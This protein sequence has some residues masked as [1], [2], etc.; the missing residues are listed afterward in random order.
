MS[1]P[2]RFRQLHDHARAE[3]VVSWELRRD[4]LQR[5]RHL[6]I[7]H[8]HDIATAISH[9]FGNRSQH[10]TQFLEVFTSLQ[11]VDHALAHG[12]I[13]MQPQSRR[14][15]I[16]YKPA[17]NTLLP[18]PLGVVG[19]ITPWNYP[20][21]L[22]IGPLSGALA[23]GNLTMI[24]LSEH[25]P[26]FG[27]LFDQLIRQ[28]FSE[29]EITV[30]NG[31]IALAREFCALPFDHLVF[32]GSTAVGREVMRAAGANLT[33]VTL[34][35]GGKSPAIIGPSADFRHAVT[36]IINGKLLNA[37]QT[38]IAPDYVL[39]PK[40][41][42]QDFIDCARDVVARF[43]PSLNDERL[44]TDDYTSIVNQR[45]YE[46]LASLCSDAQQ[47]GAV[48]TPLS[49]RAPHASTR[50]LPPLVV[51]QASA[52]AR[53]MQ[54]EIFG[55]LLPLVAYEKIG[56]AI[57]TINAGPRPLALYVFDKNPRIVERVL[58]Q[59]VSGGVAV[60]DTLLH[61]AQEDLPFGGVGASGIG[62]YH[63]EEGFRR[64]S[65]MKPVFR[66]SRIN[67]MRLFSPPYG[68]AFALLMKLLVR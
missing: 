46:R 33:P 64:F 52:E 14:T 2:L 65:H 11:A 17:R 15:S 51:T 63:G 25:T 19:I 28:S 23:A 54:E 5:L 22:T 12:H 30:V 32:T 18:Q 49:R 53:I 3:P 8:K 10:E 26:T 61:I 41:R 1:L 21:L 27:A 50:L 57:A 9:D 66:Q 68:K 34:E 62:A 40:G 7:R 58:Q 45:H 48:L 24:K 67:A 56:D 29:N 16:W 20:L 13:W 55:P 60:N 59:T 4:R 37:G 6:L 43:Y 31:D 35:L 47:R 39:L 44:P 42:E 36:R 38:C